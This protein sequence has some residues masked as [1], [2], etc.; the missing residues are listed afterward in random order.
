MASTK[1]ERLVNLVIC[2]LSSYTF[3][4]AEK[5][6]RI[7]PGYADCPTAEAFS[8]MFERDK[9]ELRDLGIPLETGSASIFDTVEGYRIK[10]D[11]Y[12]LPDIE[13][14]ADEAAAVAVAMGLWQS[15][16]LATAIQAAVVKLR[17]AGVEVDPATDDS[18]LFAAPAGLPGIHGSQ[19]ALGALMAAINAGQAVQFP[20]RSSS[21]DPYTTRTVEPWGVVTNHGRWYLVGRDRERDAVRMFRLSRIGADVVAL[22]PPG[23]VS[24][25][26]D[27][28]LRQIVADAIKETPTGVTARVWVADGRCVALR[29]AGTVAERAELDGRTGDLLA[30]DLSST[31]RLV[32]E[33]AGYGA[34]AVVLEPESLCDDVLTRLRA[35][36]AGVGS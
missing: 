14:T 16:E 21:A 7:V 4:P 15:P 3:I 35:Q 30:I 6:R 33:I 13:L 31:D 22:D 32:R 11:A 20:H 9:S 17:A 26:A 2:L 12:E 23:A 28:D 29:R 18:V 25:P 19:E 5:I 36:A 8:R 24:K 10:R 27:V 34:D 1:E